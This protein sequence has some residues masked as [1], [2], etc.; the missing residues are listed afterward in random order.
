MNACFLFFFFCPRSSRR[1]GASFR[2]RESSWT[3]RKSRRKK[4]LK[5]DPIFVSF[6][7]FPLLFFFLFSGIINRRGRTF[8]SIFIFIGE[9]DEN[10]WCNNNNSDAW[11]KKA[12]SCARDEVYRREQN[13]TRENYTRKDTYVYIFYIRRRDKCEKEKKKK[14]WQGLTFLSLVSIQSG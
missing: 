8:I 14:R 2:C 11:S 12:E 5:V 7:F 13:A 1:A 3:Q 6:F 10:P 4:D 9:R